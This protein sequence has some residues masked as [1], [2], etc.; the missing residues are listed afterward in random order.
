MVNNKRTLLEA[1]PFLNTDKA[2]RELAYNLLELINVMEIKLFQF[3]YESF[4][5]L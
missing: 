3:Q 5:Y 2:S 1:F 4:K